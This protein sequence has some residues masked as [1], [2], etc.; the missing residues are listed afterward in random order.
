M[1]KLYY[2]TPFEQEMAE[3]YLKRKTHKSLNF[4]LAWLRLDRLRN[5]F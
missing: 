1:I 3:L 4:A 2:K 5:G